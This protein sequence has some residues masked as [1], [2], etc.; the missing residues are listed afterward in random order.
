MNPKE[1]KE[2]AALMASSF[3]EDPGV[4]VQLGA[5]KQAKLLL[6]QSCKRQIRAF[7]QHNAVRVLSNGRGLLI[8]CPSTL[9]DEGEIGRNQPEAPGLMEFVSEEELWLMQS[10]TRLVEE[11]TNKDWYR[12][13]YPEEV[14]QLLVVA[15][16]KSLK[17]TG[18]LRSLLMPV[19]NE[20][21]EK[22][23]PIVMQTHNPL[24]VPIYEHFGFTVIET[25]RSIRID[26]TCYCL[27]RKLF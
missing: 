15:I 2:Y 22:K 25:R 20:C 12:Q 19:R 18:A 9:L 27:M 21:D 16:D 6:Y 23:L 17:G 10:N 26:L 5:V 11:I 8:G 1:I 13:F 24:N 7:D 14:Y 4:L 3:L